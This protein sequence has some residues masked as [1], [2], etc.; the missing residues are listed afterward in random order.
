[1]MKKKISLICASLIALAAT[2]FTSTEKKSENDLLENVF[3]EALKQENQRGTIDRNGVKYKWEIINL[4]KAPIYQLKILKE[5]KGSSNLVY[6]TDMEFKDNSLK[7]FLGKQ[8]GYKWDI[9]RSSFIL[10]KMAGSKITITAEGV[11]KNMVE[12]KFGITQQ[13]LDG[14]NLP[15]E[16]TVFHFTRHAVT[17]LIFKYKKAMKP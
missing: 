10:M 6:S 12:A 9:D 11:M 15:K 17:H 4:N 16:N 8:N 3:I 1:M 14:K 7:I 5:D 2:S 13:Q